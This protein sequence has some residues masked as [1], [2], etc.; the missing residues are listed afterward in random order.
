[1]LTAR[2]QVESF[3]MEKE[4]M[5]DV[6]VLVEHVR[7]AISGCPD[8]ANWHNNSAEIDRVCMQHVIQNSE[9]G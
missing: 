8:L 4:E 3:L 7:K 9:R 6:E 5:T 1:M 2:L